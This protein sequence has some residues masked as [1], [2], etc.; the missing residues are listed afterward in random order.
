MKRPISALLDVRGQD[1]DGKRAL[2]S[3]DDGVAPSVVLLDGNLPRCS[4]GTNRPVHRSRDLQRKL[5]FRGRDGLAQDLAEIDLH[6][7]QNGSLGPRCQQL[8][9]SPPQVAVELSIDAPCNTS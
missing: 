5:E 4:R 2:W 7:G 8:I 6:A 9:C 3:R 1:D